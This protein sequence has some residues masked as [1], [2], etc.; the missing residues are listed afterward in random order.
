M[1]IDNSNLDSNDDETD[2]TSKIQTINS[3]SEDI[4]RRFSHIQELKK[5][6][7]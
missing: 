5:N 2:H 1:E 6:K 3:S 7:K 4:L